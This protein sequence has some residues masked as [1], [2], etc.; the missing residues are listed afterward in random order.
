MDAPTLWLG[1]S[2]LP[3]AKQRDFLARL[4]YNAPLVPIL[5][6]MIE[7]QTEP[8]FDKAAEQHFEAI[9]HQMKLDEGLEE[10]KRVREKLFSRLDRV[11]ALPTLPSVASLVFRIAT[12]PTSSAGDLTKVIENDQSLTSKLLKTVNSAFYGFP[13]K[14]GT[15]KQAVVILGLD[16]ITNL[17]FGLAAAKVLETTTFGGLY[18]PKS[19]WHHSICTALIAQ[20]LCEGFPR[21]KR[22]GVFT[23]GL[24]HDFGKILL[25]ETFPELYAQIYGEVAKHDFPLFDLEEEKI[26][27]N[28]AVV[29]RLLSSNWNLPE[30]LVE[31]IAYH[32]HPLSAPRYTH[33]AAITGLADYLYYRSTAAG[34]PKE[35]IL[36]MSPQL[37]Y[38]HWCSLTEVFTSLNA[39]QLKQMMDDALTVVE[40]SNEL[41]NVLD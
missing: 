12:D 16:E 26:G 20:K 10:R 11:D 37:T 19:L 32:H 15:V 39:E 21:F 13:Q 38:G 22:L 7:N 18:D 9:I 23:A 6:E 14:I 27:V 31:A 5:K 25:M 40:N 24:L 3:Q 8:A 4:P 41:L 30:S 28:H 33:L 29:G 17:A 2:Q 34:N 36:V 1:L 35:A